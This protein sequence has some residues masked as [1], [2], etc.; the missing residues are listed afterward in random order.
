MLVL[1]FKKDL[2]S[3]FGRGGGRTL[4]GHSN[5]AVFSQLNRIGGMTVSAAPAGIDRWIW[6]PTASTSAMVAVFVF[7]GCMPGPLNV[8][9]TLLSIVACPVAV[10][11]LA[12]WAFALFWRRRPRGG[13]SAF[14]AVV[15]PAFLVVPMALIQAYVHLGLTVAFG[16]GY[17]G[18]AP[19]KGQPVGIYDWSTG[20]VGGPNTFLIHDTTDAV[21]VAAVK[22]GHSGWR[23]TDF[24]R[25]C[26]GRSRHLIGHYYV[27]VV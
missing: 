23:N 13:F 25:E 19:Q 27:C 7:V 1:V 26:A 8:P 4:Y 17:L 9:V 12:G 10:L 14:L 21:A 15:V 2:L 3:G 5:T 24:L 11:L 20:V 16:I 18:G 6:W 22:G